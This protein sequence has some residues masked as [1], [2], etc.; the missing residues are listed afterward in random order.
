MSLCFMMGLSIKKIIM[1]V[2]HARAGAPADIRSLSH[3]LVCVF[4]AI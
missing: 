4:N 2:P 3:V 1:V